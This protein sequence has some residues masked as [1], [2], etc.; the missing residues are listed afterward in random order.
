L[1][2]QVVWFKG[3]LTFFFRVVNMCNLLKTCQILFVFFVAPLVLVACGGGSNSKSKPANNLVLTQDTQF[4]YVQRNVTSDTKINAERLRLSK[5]SQQTSPLDLSSPYQFRPGAQLLSR[6]SLDVNAVDTEVLTQYFKSAEYDVKDLNVSPDGQFLVFAAH[7]PRESTTDYTW[8]IYE[9]S[10]TAKTVRRI[11]ADN[12]I[13][14]AGQD[15]NPTYATD[16][17]IVFSSDRSAG[18]P[19]SPID[20][21]VDPDQVKNCYKV[22]PNE[23]PSLL[24]SMTNQ[25]EHIV[26]LTYG[27]NHDTK[28]TTLKDGRI[29]FVRWSRS[30]ELLKGCPVSGE[31]STDLFSAKYPKG[32]DVP[33]EWSLEAKCALA[34]ETPKG[35]VLPSN[36]Y[37]ILRITAD[38]EELQQLYKTVTMTGSDDSFLGIDHLVQTENG[39]LVAVVKHAYNQFLG[40]NVLELES[41][42][43]ATDDK[44]FGNIAPNE[45]IAKDVDLYPSQ[46]SVSGWYSAVWPYRD[47]SD[48]L[49][50]SWSQCSAEK[51]G[52]NSFC[53]S[54]TQEGEVNG[55]Y[56][57]WVVDQNTDSRLPVVRAR[58]NIVYSDIAISQPQSGVDYPFEAYKVDFVDDLDTS[59]LICD[60][61]GVVPPNSSSYA[62]S[63]PVYS[64]SYASSAPVVKSSAASTPVVITRSSANSVPVI[65]KSSAMSIPVVT[66]SRPAV[67]SSATVVSSFSRSSAGGVVSSLSRSSSPVNR[68]SFAA[69]STPANTV[70]VAN[71]G[72]DQLAGFG[73]KVTLDGSASID[74]DG[75]ALTY[76]WT[77]I[78]PSKTMAKLSDASAVMPTFTVKEHGTYIVQLVVNDGKVNSL[79]DT[80]SFEVNN[81]R[82]VAN[83]GADLGAEMNDPLQ[84]N[85][86]LSSDMDG[87]PLT[88]QWRIVSG[89][90]M[91]NAQLVNATSVVPSFTPDKQGLYTVEL[92]VNDGF[93]SSAPDTMVIDTMNARPVANAGPDQLVAIS[94]LALLSG[95]ASSDAD[96]DILTYKW[97]L[98]S[99]PSDS[100]TK[101]INPTDDMPQL[102]IDVAGNYVLQLVVNDG[103]QDSEPDTVVLN[104]KNIRPIAEAGKNVTVYLGDKVVLDGS[105]SSDADGDALSYRWNLLSKPNNSIA[106]LVNATNVSTSFTADKLGSFVAQLVVNDGKLDSLPDTVTITVEQ[107]ACN[108]DSTTKRTLPVV[109]RDFDKSHPDFEKFNGGESGIVKFQLG[110]DSLPVYAKR[111]GASSTTT[112]AK[113]FNQWYRDVKGVN[114]RMP[115]TLQMTR[116]PGSTTWSYM[117]T[118]FFPIDG[119]GFGNMAKPAPDHNYHFTL[120]AHLKFDYKGGEVFTFRGDDDLWVFINGKLAIDIGGV[121]GVLESTINLN[122]VATKLGIEKGKSYNFDLFFAERHT[123]KSNFMFQTNINL[124]CTPK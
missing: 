56:G 30:Y 124:E 22:G 95:N 120:E 81:M 90:Q 74:A 48:R 34:Q 26:Q 39:Q 47:G 41:P 99:K 63:T 78:S 12:A 113:N 98:L 119:L 9:Y 96:G 114:I 62:S 15:T 54:N 57:I 109:I 19:N 53:K 38:G 66:S 17:S 1:G 61:P 83:A 37:T 27:K 72:P 112:S 71:A 105:A 64:S 33:A 104:T 100:K 69:S 110:S 58:K 45:F 73:A 24:H 92:V 44:V 65:V 102:N 108:L 36:H 52:V 111:D 35:K 42:A 50:V 55:Q 103:F 11:I 60:D 91:S 67:F 97:S 79:P 77:I 121:H 18:N 75:D 93:A 3:V 87:D 59:R 21:I 84:L 115:Y 14:N 70:P 16:G 123:T 10:F 106:S 107:P 80:V 68:S 88:Y 28:P 7:G 49:L 46:R 2:G 94:E 13:A 116:A 89:P 118:S 6:S 8:N 82:P 20:N 51:N 29:A 31:A 32:L 86:S 4:A 5:A 40:G 76:R 25:G 101:L 23:K 122:E 43:A 117:N 85:G